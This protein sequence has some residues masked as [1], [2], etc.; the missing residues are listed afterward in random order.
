M[1]AGEPNPVAIGSSSSLGSKLLAA[2]TLAA[3]ALVATPGASLAAVEGPTR[4]EAVEA[5]LVARETA[6]VPGKPLTLGLRLLH[7]PHWHSYWR[8]PGDSGLPTQLELS[9]PEGFAASGF[10]WP[11]PQRLFIPPLANYG[12]EGEVVLPLRVSVPAGFDGASLRITGKASWLM[13]SDVCIPGDAALALTLPV[14][15]DGNTSPS[16][17]AALF[18]AAHRR[19]PGDTLEVQ[20]ESDGETLSLGLPEALASAEFFPYHEGLVA[21]AAAQPLHAIDAEGQP[22]RRLELRLSDEGKRR[23]ADAAERLK[24]AE[25]VLVAGDR[26][27]E[28]KPVVAQRPLDAGVEISRIAG[29]DTAPAPDSN[30]GRSGGGVFS[31]LFSR[32]GGGESAAGAGTGASGTTGASGAIGA[33]GATGSDASPSAGGLGAGGPGGGR[34]PGS[35]RLGGVAGLMVAASFAAV[36]GLILNLMPCVFPVI[37]L[38]VLGFAG[39]GGASDP[40]RQRSANR[41]SRRS[42]FAFSAGV[43][44]SFWLLAALL[45]GLRGAGQAVGW[46]FQLQSPAFV[47]AMALLFVAIGLN[48][49]GVWEFGLGMT[50]LGQY[51]HRKGSAT[52]GSFGAGVLAVLVAT[53]CTAP[54]MGSALGY[55]LSASVVETL[56]VFTALGLGMALPYLLLGSFPAWLRHLPR[57]G[58]WMESFRQA[59]AFPMYATAA[60]LA[61][62]LG[63]QAGLD[64]MFALAIG[65]VL[66]G[67]AAWLYGRFV[68]QAQPVRVDPVRARHRRGFAASLAVLSLAAGLLIA[69][70]DEEAV[71]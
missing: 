32:G 48:F 19:L 57:P 24:A 12:Y 34:S 67:L 47:A 23:V 22:A 9:L 27:F 37:G 58:R 64:A 69:W 4:V 52:S 6:V 15:R 20:V 11:A 59:L 31:S 62:V 17:H 54:F 56:V 46:G 50:R 29:A 2:F 5:E 44:L 42:A 18:D 3:A 51:E 21:N 68:Q 25:G 63:R 45:L 55:T 61:W 13:C 1:F 66:F 28:L 40:A 33:S 8:N 38:K 70:P 7:D 41:A 30:A 35:S 26:I 16:R 53:P 10:E 36:G 43:L 49:S 14:S 60:W 65:A 39:H 71:S